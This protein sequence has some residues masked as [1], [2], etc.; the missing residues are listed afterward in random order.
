MKVVIVNTFDT[1]G[2]ASIAANRLHRYFLESNI[3]ST[4]IV[5]YKKSTYPNVL[6][7]TNYLQSLKAIART[8][9]DTIF[10]RFY[11]RRTHEIYSLG[12][13][14]SS[15]LVNKINNLKPDIVHLHWITAGTISVLDLSKIKGKIVW[16]MH[17]MWSFT[18]GCHYNNECLNYLLECNKCPILGSQR[19]HDLSLLS[20]NIKKKFYPDKLSFIGLSMWI[21]NEAK[22]SKLL[23]NH[24]IVNLPNPID[25]D[26]FSPPE[27]PKIRTA[28]KK[29]LF[30]AQNNSEYRKGFHLLREA[31]N[32]LKSDEI[33]FC[34]LG[35]NSID[36][37]SNEFT[38]LGNITNE[39]DLVKVYSQ[40]DLVVVPSIQE[41]FSNMILE[42]LACGIP[43]VAFNIGGNCDLI[44]HKFNGFLAQPF[45]PKDLR[46][47]I[48][49]S[50]DNVLELSTNS[51][52]FV[53]ENFEKTK[54]VQ[55]YLD[56]YESSAND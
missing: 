54:V 34:I 38:Y 32:L 46:D 24:K 56:F 10:N 44:K 5:S 3:D 29:I 53:L 20:F 13:V 25:C 9:L 11:F 27:K 52:N 22:K 50:L 36:D 7:T 30:G 23:A 15:A 16:S 33:E 40:M 43:V 12:I 49:W 35:S 1:H 42:S 14:G 51:R 45:S 37:R 17:D 21:T 8:Y 55:Q 26:L 41:N 47:G 31:I 6:G 48:I 4:M 2:G 39:I 18:G 19:R 28:K